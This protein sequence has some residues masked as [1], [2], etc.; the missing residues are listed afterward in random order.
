[1]GPHATPSVV[2]ERE[3]AD[4]RVRRDIEEVVRNVVSLGVRDAL[5]GEVLGRAEPTR[6]GV[7]RAPM[8]KHEDLVERMV[9]L[10]T[11]RRTV[12]TEK[13]AETGRRTSADE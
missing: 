5:R 6:P 8:G 3:E 10:G 12:S 1:M 13:T 4:G 9:E 11:T 7:Q 2:P